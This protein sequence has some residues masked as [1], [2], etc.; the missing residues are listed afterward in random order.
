MPNPSGPA[1]YSI[2]YQTQTV[3]I[4]PDGRPTDGWKV[5][6]H[7]Y[8]SGVDGSVFIPQ[9][10]FNANTV[11]QAIAEQLAHHDAIAKLTGV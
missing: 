9:A 4:G 6:Y 5:G 3:G 8:A 7:V 11:K 1:V 10:R 2:T